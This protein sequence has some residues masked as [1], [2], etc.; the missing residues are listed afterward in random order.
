MSVENRFNKLL[1]LLSCN[2]DDVIKHLKINWINSNEKLIGKCPSCGKEYY[3]DCYKKICENC[4]T[5]FYL[6][7]TLDEDGL[8]KIKVEKIDSKKC[9]QCGKI[10]SE[11][12]KEY[13]DECHTGNEGKYSSILYDV[14][15]ICWDGITYSRKATEKEIDE[16]REKG[17]VREDESGITFDFR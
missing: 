13:C 4:G 10:A 3:Y 14:K 8:Y 9:L 16:Q 15:I 12:E 2:K 11:L 6:K 7:K 5:G 17:F 1:E